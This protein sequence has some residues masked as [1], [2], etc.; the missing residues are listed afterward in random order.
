MP[1]RK[2]DIKIGHRAYYEAM[3]IFGDPSEASRKLR[4]ERTAVYKWRGGMVP[5]GGTLA[6]MAWAGA[7]VNY[8]LTGRRADNGKAD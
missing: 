7:D 1:M 2:A 8:I 4:V 6:K 3:R 5:T